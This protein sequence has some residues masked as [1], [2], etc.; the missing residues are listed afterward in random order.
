MKQEKEKEA[1]SA[2]SF[3]RGSQ[4]TTECKMAA[5]EGPIS[6]QSSDS[7]L[8]SARDR[9]PSSSS[10]NGIIERDSQWRIERS[11]LLNIAKI[12]I[13]TLIDSSLKCGRILTDDFPP[14]NQFFIVMEH[15]FRHGLK[16]NCFLYFFCISNHGCSAARL[17]SMA[18]FKTRSHQFIVHATFCCSTLLL[19]YSIVLLKS[20]GLQVSCSAVRFTRSPGVHYA[21]Y[22]IMTPMIMP[23]KLVYS[24]CL[25]I[26]WHHHL[27]L[28]ACNVNELSKV[29]I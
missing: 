20:S 10:S 26:Q 25:T 2:A 15:V 9:T 6:D 19:A 5:Q 17:K 8:V 23:Q 12:C 27:T 14:L 3:R 28:L 16:G 11:N 4:S 7:I 22:V 1:F 29:T 18:I 13:K 24:A 21:M